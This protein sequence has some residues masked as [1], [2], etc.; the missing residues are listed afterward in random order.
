MIAKIQ[1]IGAAQRVLAVD[2]GFA[3]VWPLAV[4]GPQEHQQTSD[5]PSNVTICALLQPQHKRVDEFTPFAGAA[6]LCI[7]VKSLA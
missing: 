2:C 4:D 5:V 7:I 6:L 3:P 1:H